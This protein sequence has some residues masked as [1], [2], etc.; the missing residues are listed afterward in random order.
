ME[1]VIS[2]ERYWIGWINMVLKSVYENGGFW[3][4]RYEA[5]ITTN[6]TSKNEEITAEPL[7]KQGTVENA[8][9]PYTY[10]T[11][12]QAQTIAEHVMEE[13]MQTVAKDNEC[14]Y[15]PETGL[16]IRIV[17]GQIIEADAEKFK[18]IDEQ[19][20]NSGRKVKQIRTNDR[21]ERDI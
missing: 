13:L 18:K 11:C 15:D 2:D 12:S 4:G 5:G 9:Y 1:Y 10:V 16:A 7:S 21:T 19:R 20:K 8:V 17:D 3:I 14:R 6:R